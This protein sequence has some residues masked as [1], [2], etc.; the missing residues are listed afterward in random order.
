[1]LSPGD[2]A[3]RPVRIPWRCMKMPR[4]G[5]DFA[6]FRVG[7]VASR[8]GLAYSTVANGRAAIT[9][10][11]GGEP[12]R[13][14]RITTSGHPR[15]GKLVARRGRKAMGPSQDGLP[16]YRRDGLAKSP[17]VPRQCFSD[18]TTP[19]PRSG[20]RGNPV[21]ARFAPPIFSAEHLST[22]QCLMDCGQLAPR[23]DGK[24]SQL[25]ERVGHHAF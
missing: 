22:F 6:H 14:A 4:S 1:V 21:T 18:D 17:S 10:P 15:K 23:V 20:D 16:G 3:S 19:D 12:W 7:L 2:S 13:R 5:P 24:Q 8:R 9:G 25:A 11:A